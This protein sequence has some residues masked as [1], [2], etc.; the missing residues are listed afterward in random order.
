MKMQ[1]DDSLYDNPENDLEYQ[2]DMF[3]DEVLFAKDEET[4]TPTGMAYVPVFVM[5]HAVERLKRYQIIV[6]NLTE[7]GNLLWM[8]NLK[9]YGGRK[10]H[11][12][13]T[14]SGSI[15]DKVFRNMSAFVNELGDQITLDDAYV[16]LALSMVRIQQGDPTG[17][18]QY[19]NK[20]DD[21]FDRLETGE[22][23]G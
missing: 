12:K 3:W 15:N 5:E 8:E 23:N 14:P 11:E 19:L 21:L 10:I 20:E 2:L 4:D 18:A 16:E 13:E 9:K 17:W 1:D 22:T 6:E 7:V